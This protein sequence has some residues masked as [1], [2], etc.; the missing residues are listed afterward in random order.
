MK[1]RPKWP[2]FWG[3]CSIFSRCSR[4]SRYSRF[5][6]FS[7]FSRSSI[8]LFH[9]F[10]SILDIDAVGEGAVYL[11]SVKGEDAAVIFTRLHGD[12]ANA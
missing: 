5:S 2:L 10:L 4:F 12:A 9:D 6:R 7:R 3:G 11:S 8:S 1:K